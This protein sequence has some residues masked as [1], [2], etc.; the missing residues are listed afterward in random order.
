MAKSPKYTLISYSLNLAM[1]GKVF[2]KFTERHHHYRTKIKSSES[3]NLFTD[4]NFLAK[5]AI[6]VHRTLEEHTLES[7]S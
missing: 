3:Q 6:L 7:Q 2:L 5:T 4:I 1:D